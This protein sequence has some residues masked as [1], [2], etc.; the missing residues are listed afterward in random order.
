VL[1]IVGVAPAA[2]YG[3]AVGTSTD[4][5]IPMMM[6]PAAMPGR[7]WLK[8]RKASWVSVMGRRKKG[9]SQE[10]A[11]A[12]LAVPWRQILTDEAGAQITD[13]RKRSIA[14][15]TSDIVSSALR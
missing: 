13:A 9:V 1:T 4:M 11:S 5:W 6:Q 15:K 8:Q 3:D 2:F 7:P 14:Q 10:Q 12:A